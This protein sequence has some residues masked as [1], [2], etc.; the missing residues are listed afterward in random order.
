MRGF[1]DGDGT[2]YIYKVN[3]A[4]QIKAGFVSPTLSFITKFNQQLCENLNIPQKAIHKSCSKD[5][6]L[7]QYSICFYID[8]CEK[9]AKLKMEIN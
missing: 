2:V 5:K 6:K 4:P 3:G 1:F 7:T 9:L 8:D